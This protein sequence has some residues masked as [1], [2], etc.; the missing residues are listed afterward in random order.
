MSIAL[1]TI[2]YH[3]LQATRVEPSVSLRSE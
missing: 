3:T 2:G 1:V